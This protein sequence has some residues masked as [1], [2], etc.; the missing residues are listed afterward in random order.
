MTKSL[1]IFRDIEKS[2]SERK[3]LKNIN[4]NLYESKC[5][6]LSG[7]NGSGKSTLLKILAGLEKPDIAK[8]E[9]SGSLYSWKKIIKYI[10]KNIIYLH[11]QPF[12]FSGSVEY[13]V[14]YGL[15]FSQLN[16]KERREA[17]IEALEWSGL[18]DF[19]RCQA[20]TLSG[21]VQQR[22][23]FTRAWI[24]KP[25]VLLLDE[26]I[27]NMD[28]ESRE[29]VCILLR[30][31]K[32]EGLSIVITSHITQNIND[33]VD[34]HFFLTEGLLEESKFTESIDEIV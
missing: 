30:R 17:L 34:F 1:F 33:L 27:S 2:F 16:R 22:V 8:I 9:V 32:S 29:K 4:L 31:M 12:L 3:I 20:N 25:K 10:R 6:L 14:S 21:G 7:K 24:L 26:P 23:A 5:V 19:A 15:R 28:D 13:N 11:Q 18:T